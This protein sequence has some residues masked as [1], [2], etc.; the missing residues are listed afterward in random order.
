ME[1]YGP[2][3]GDDIISDVRGKQRAGYGMADQRKRKLDDIL[4][5]LE[6]LGGGKREKRME[7]RSE[8]KE[9]TRAGRSELIGRQE[10]KIRRTKRF[11]GSQADSCASRSS[12]G[13]VVKVGTTLGE[14]EKLRG[15]A[16]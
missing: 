9:K 15:S 3:A 12:L 14:R 11:T 1:D 8:E 6:D 2:S 10:E 13:A 16:Q 4:D 7:G 5:D